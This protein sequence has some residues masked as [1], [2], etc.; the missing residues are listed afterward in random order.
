MA[1]T[2]HAEFLPVP[3]RL[4]DLA[5]HFSNA[6]LQ[7]ETLCVNAHG[8]AKYLLSRAVRDA[9]YKVVLTG[10]GADELLGGYMH[11]GRD[12]LLSASKPTSATSAASPTPATSTPNTLSR[13]YRT[14]AVDVIG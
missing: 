13:H 7:A 5:D 9:G 1:A 11:F 10:E 12:M 3:I 2:V 6:I 4:D 8:V 14:Y